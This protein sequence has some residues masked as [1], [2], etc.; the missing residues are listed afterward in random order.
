[1]ARVYKDPKKTD[2]CVNEPGIAYQK[3]D[4]HED[5]TMTKAWN[6]NVPFQ[7]TEDDWQEH[8]YQIE[9]EHFTPLTTANQEFEEWRTKLLA[10]RL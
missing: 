4:S 10:S 7:G 1:M 5:N 6:P 8:F 2:K 9:R 3:L